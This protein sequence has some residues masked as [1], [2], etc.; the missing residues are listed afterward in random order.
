MYLDAP[1]AGTSPHKGA[2][3]RDVFLRQ[4]RGLP[5]HAQRLELATFRPAAAHGQHSHREARMREFQVVILRLQG[6]A[7]E[8]EDAMTDLMNERARMGWDFHSIEP[9]PDQKVVVVFSREA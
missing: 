9:L 6:K 7:R 3:H 5:T 1:A 8:D 2:Q 4:S